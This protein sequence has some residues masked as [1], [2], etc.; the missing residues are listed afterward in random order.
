M[1][2]SPLRSTQAL[3]K[4]RELINAHRVKDGRLP[5]EPELA[6]QLGVSRGTV[7][8][9]LSE[10]EREGLIQRRHGVGTFINERVLNVGSRLEEVWDFEEMITLSGYK[11]GVRHV[12]LSLEPAG[13]ALAEKLSLE[14]GE[15]V[16]VTANVFLADG[17]PVIYCVDILPAK[18]VESAYRQEE[19]YGPVY[20]FLEKRCNQVVDY[21]ITQIRPVV[22]DE[23]LSILLECKVGDPL[24]FF[25]EVGF[26]REDLP[27]IYSEEYYC[28][29]YF[30]FNIVRK[31]TT[32]RKENLIT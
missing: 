3:I 28:P 1:Q 29:E 15:E 12:S 18:L 23:K 31:M 22:A 9:A 20:T 14:C 27:I 30:S 5:S 19:L 11:S 6:Q 24:H 2:Q 21:N 7:R 4:I 10:L 32:Q 8:Q 17:V 25:E 26:N 16:L 13:D